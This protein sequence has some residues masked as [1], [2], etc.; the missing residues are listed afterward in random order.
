LTGQTFVQKLLSAWG[1]ADAAEAGV[2]FEHKIAKGGAGGGVGFADAL[3]P[4]KVLIE[5]KPRGERLAA[6]F[7][8]LYRYWFYLTPKPTYAILCN[9]DEFWV[10]DF[11]I[12]S[13]EPIE[14]LQTAQLAERW[15][16]LA[17]LSKQ[18]QTPLFGNNQVT[19]TEM[20]AKAMGHLFHELKRQ[21]AETGQFT[22][23]QA[24]RFVL[25]CVLC[26]FAEDREM[27]PNRQFSLA[28][29]VCREKN[30]STFDVLSGLFHAMN[31][32]GTTEAGRFKG[33]PYFNGGLFSEIP[34]IE[35]S[36][37]QLGQLIDS[38]RENWRMV[39]PS[40]FGNIFEASSD[41]IKRHALGQHFTSESDILKVVRPTIIEPW[42]GRIE[43]A[44]T[45]SELEQLL[46]ELR[47]F[48]VLDPACGSG[49]FLYMSYN[50]LK[51]IEAKILGRIKDRRQSKELKALGSFGFVTTSQFLGMDI[52]PFAV[53]LARV[54]LMIARKIAHDRLE[55]FRNRSCPWITLTKISSRP[56][57][58]L[59][60]GQRLMPL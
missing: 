7:P 24:Q 16:G 21:S 42:E 5:M 44:K 14:L 51:D 36:P 8:Q 25:Q 33:T 2:S 39:R 17:F 54:T 46:I 58:F 10:Y 13:D 15:P 3:I 60:H 38:A 52:D 4:G 37:A 27:L 57:H 29:E 55:Y 32:P 19:V 22:E 43:T 53:E 23:Q 40:I 20:Q 34:R 11:N 9:F 47:A 28:L 35:L 30:E 49:N 45:I 26:M 48:R 59:R 31:S 56:M 12:Q 18:P 50:G 41:D 1:W 6:H